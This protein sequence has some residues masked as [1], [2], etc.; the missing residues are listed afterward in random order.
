MLQKPFLALCS[1]RAIQAKKHPTSFT[2]EDW[3]S[4]A[5]LIQSDNKFLGI[6]FDFFVNWAKAPV[7]VTQTIWIKRILQSDYN[8]AQV[9]D[10]LNAILITEFT[11][12]FLGR[13]FRFCTTAQLQLQI[14]IFRDDYDWSNPKSDVLIVTVKKV[15]ESNIEFTAELVSIGEF[16][17]DIRRYSGGAISVGR[18]GLIYGTS[19]LEC[20]LSTS[21]SAYPGDVDK[22]L[23]SADTDRPVAILE[24]K[25]HTKT[26]LIDTQT[27]MNYYPGLDSRKYDR[28]ATLR[29][30]ISPDKTHI[31]I[32]VLHY[33]T[34]A[35]IKDGKIELIDGEMGKLKPIGASKFHLPEDNSAKEF[36]KAIDAVSEAITE[37]YARS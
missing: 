30:Y 37:Y 1:N 26:G 10:D 20:F 15:S 7:E 8:Y 21:D 4:D 23:L 34:E 3:F 22:V 6:E 9:I 5:S 12:A 18:K 24:F 35:S 16:K 27:M 17:A 36:L 2:P 28:L 25:K 32:I 14:I 29:N 11:L 33:P 31:P 19:R 13:M